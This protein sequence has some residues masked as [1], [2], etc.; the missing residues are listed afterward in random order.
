M[1]SFPTTFPYPPKFR[2]LHICIPIET[3]FYVPIS[4][5]SR[6]EDSTLLSTGSLRIRFNQ[7]HP[8]SPL[9]P[10]WTSTTSKQSGAPHGKPGSNRS[11]TVSQ[12]PSLINEDNKYPSFRGL[13]EPSYPSSRHPSPNQSR[14][15][16]HTTHSSRSATRLG[17]SKVA[18]CTRSSTVVPVKAEEGLSLAS[19]SNAQVKPPLE[20]SERVPRPESYPDSRVVV[21]DDGEDEFV[22]KNERNGATFVTARIEVSKRGRSFLTPDFGIFVLINV[23]CPNDGLEERS[24]FKMNFHYVLE[25]RLRAVMRERREV[26]SVGDLNTWVALID[27]CEGNFIIKRGLAEGKDGKT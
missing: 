2:L 22:N 4:V 9:R 5:L 23:Y 24:P 1:K 10:Q 20:L 18:T 15:L 11:L 12:T 26:V 21:V 6:R 13:S 8:S 27:H 14:L 25:D 16:S 19:C 7:Q 17:Y 3:V